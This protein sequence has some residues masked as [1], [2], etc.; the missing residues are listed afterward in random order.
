VETNRLKMGRMHP[1]DAN[2]L[3]LGTSVITPKY[4]NPT[5]HPD[6]NASHS[7]EKIQKHAPSVKELGLCV[8]SRR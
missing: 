7:I 8:R 4:I 2:R 3:I 5:K 6:V 1:E